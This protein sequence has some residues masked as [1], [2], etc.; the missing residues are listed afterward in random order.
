MGL[1]SREAECVE[2]VERRGGE[3]ITH[4]RGIKEMEGAEKKAKI[5]QK[6]QVLTV[7]VLLRT[8]LFPQNLKDQHSQG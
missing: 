1:G 3:E 6:Q 5:C 8:D 7:A 4:C 2:G